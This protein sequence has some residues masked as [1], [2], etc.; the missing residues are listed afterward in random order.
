VRCSVTC[1][2][3]AVV[4]RKLH[5]R[6]PAEQGTSNPARMTISD[7]GVARNVAET[8]ARLGVAVALVSRIG[9]DD[10]GGGICR[11]LAGVG[12]DISRMVAVPGGQTAEYVAV[13]AE[14]DLLIAAAAMDVLDGIGLGDLDRCWPS[15]SGRPWLF[16]DCN[17]PAP[18]VAAA[19]AR[20]ATSGGAVRL[21]VDAVSTPKVT[22]LPADLS[23][24]DVLFCN[25]AE[26]RAWLSRHRRDHAG[27]DRQLAAGMRAAGAAGVVLS[28]GAAGLVVADV[29]GVREV[30]AVPATVVDVTGAGDA[31]VGGTLAGLLDGLDLAAAANRGALL[32]ALTVQS[33][34]TVRPDLSRALASGIP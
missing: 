24:V 14:R 16:V 22:R 26:A 11:R 15:G 30:G 9:D 10:A 12:V 18:V 19:V 1:L 13:L 33:E 31:L 21:A 3:G 20:A 27:D 25:R 5:L 4:D 23:G 6:A 34:H 29:D 2:G 32:A 8:L 17:C 7:G 28:R